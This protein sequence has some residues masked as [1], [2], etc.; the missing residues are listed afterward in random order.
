MYERKSHQAIVGTGN[1][2]HGCGLPLYGGM[3]DDFDVIDFKNYS[4]YAFFL[5]YVLSNALAILGVT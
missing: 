5:L 3:M 1:P 2:V 4:W